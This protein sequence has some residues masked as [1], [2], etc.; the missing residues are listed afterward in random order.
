MEYS[1]Y[2]RKP[3]TVEAVQITE[4]NIEE[5]AELVGEIKEKDGQKYIALNWRAVPGVNRAYVGWYLTRF[6]D[7][8]RCFS[9]KIFKEQFEAVET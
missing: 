3:F 9:P 8:L 4:E 7:N 1:P 6:G 5:V 2:V